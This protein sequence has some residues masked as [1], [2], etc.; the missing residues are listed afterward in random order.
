MNPWLERQT[1]FNHAADS[2]LRSV[3][4]YLAD[5]ADRVNA[6]QAELAR[7]AI[8]LN[9]QPEPTACCGRHGGGP[10]TEIPDDPIRVV[11]DLFLDTRLPPPPARVLVLT[12]NGQSSLDLASRGYQVVQCAA[13]VGPVAI[14]ERRSRPSDTDGKWPFPDESF[15]VAI[16]LAGD[17]VNGPPG[18]ATLSLL[19]RVL[20]Q[21]GRV[22]GSGSAEMAS[23]FGPLRLVE[24][25]YAIRAPQGWS[26]TAARTDEADLTLWVAAKN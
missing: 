14:S 4:G 23:R 9:S 20:T 13:D 8:A 19:A 11:E 24:R 1:Q 17:R 25:V 16:A 12:P 5:V 3:H 26:L 21:D 15:D 22:I 2:Y 6:L 10:G 18:D 7:Q